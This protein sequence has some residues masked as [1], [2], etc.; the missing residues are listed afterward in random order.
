VDGVKVAFQ[1]EAG[2][3]SEEAAVAL[4]PGAAPLPRRT[5]AE[6][7]RAVAVGEADFGVVA[8]ENSQSGSINATYDLLRQHDLFILAELYLPVS[9]CL[10]APKGTALRD[11]RR[12]LS[13]PAALEQCVE[14]LEKIGAE[15][16]AIHD[17]AG[18]ARHVAEE[19]PAATAAIASPRAAALYGLDILVRDVQT[20]RDNTTRFLALGREPAK[21]VEGAA[22][23]TAIVMATD[24]R[25]GA[26]H[27]ALGAVAQE[28]VNL[29]KLESRPSRQRAFESV[30]YLDLEG[31]RD[32]A[33]VRAA[34]ANLA[35]ATTF[36]KVLGSFPRARDPGR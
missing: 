12:V 18:A 5:L 31:H 33:G 7:F 36:L 8:V 4:F 32:D 20:A 17:T 13:H 10:M 24:D 28:G 14:F 23:K 15:A 29:L 30:F 25:P 3:F 6:A 19:R 2:A 21:R 34:L 22:A 16:V 35:R 9:Q 11:V 27:R 26:L 1:G